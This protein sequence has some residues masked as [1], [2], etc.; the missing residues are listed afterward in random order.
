M[1]CFRCI[2]ACPAGARQVADAGFAEFK[3]NF[4][5]RLSPLH[6]EPEMFFVE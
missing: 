2:N 5:K 4:E 1:R 6:K 3:S